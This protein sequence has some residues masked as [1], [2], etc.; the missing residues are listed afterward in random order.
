MNFCKSQKNRVKRNH[1]ETIN[2]Q[3]KFASNSILPIVPMPRS[4]CH[5]L[6]YVKT[7]EKHNQL[8]NKISKTDRVLK[9]RNLSLVTQKFIRIHNMLDNLQSTTDWLLTLRKKRNE[10]IM[11]RIGHMLDAKSQN[12]LKTFS[13]KNKFH[14]NRIQAFC[15]PLKTRNILSINNADQFSAHGRLFKYVRNKSNQRIIRI[16]QPIQVKMIE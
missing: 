5:I 16:P 11:V 8:Y 13:I 6:N 1:Y 2:N 9:D 15:T 12:E 7:E 4:R 14:T 10:K 3:S